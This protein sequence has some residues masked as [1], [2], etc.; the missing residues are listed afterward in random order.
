MVSEEDHKIRQDIF[1]DDQL[2]EDKDYG[3]PPLK[4]S[5]L[6]EIIP[7]N[8]STNKETDK[9]VIKSKGT[10]K[11]ANLS[12]I[13]KESNLTNINNPKMK[14]TEN[15]NFKLILSVVLCIVLVTV[16]VLYVLSRSNV[17]VPV[18]EEIKVKIESP[19]TKQ[20]EKRKEVI[21]E[22]EFVKEEP[23]S[24]NQNGS[25]NIIKSAQSKFYVIS[26]SFVDYDLAIDY[27]NDL[28]E[29]GVNATV[30]APESNWLTRVAIA[31]LSTQENLEIELNKLK[32]NFGNE[33]WGLSY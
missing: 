31:E 33:I 9:V 12:G 15:K 23:L 28:A 5:V 29:R 2:N 1:T 8:K 11:D 6:D 20:P 27:A 13:S 16:I 26:C 14:I 25:V 30:I 18:K 22:V 10:K 21:K 19:V 24:P 7:P 32:Q 17:D 3:L 4:F